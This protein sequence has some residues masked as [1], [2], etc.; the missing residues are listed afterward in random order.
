MSTPAADELPETLRYD[1]WAAAVTE[2]RLLGQEC[3]D[4]GHVGGTPKGAC[5]HCGARDLTTVELPTQGEVYSET[6]IN[7]PPEGFEERGYQVAIV[8]LGDARL[9]VH[10]DADDHVE[11]GADVSLSGCIDTDEGHPAPTFEPS[12]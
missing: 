12:E 3:A 9:T 8:D 7:V 1:D 4:C 10:V 5:P 2:G 6:T 11:V